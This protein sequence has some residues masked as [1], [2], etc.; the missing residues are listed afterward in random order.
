MQQIE[1]QDTGYLSGCL[2]RPVRNAEK[3][4]ALCDESGKDYKAPKLKLL[5]N[6]PSS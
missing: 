2:C 3:V 6:P 1:L 5:P 4:P